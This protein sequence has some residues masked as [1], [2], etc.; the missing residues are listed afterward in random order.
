MLNEWAAYFAEQAARETGVGSMWQAY[1]RVQDAADWCE[2]AY[3][4]YE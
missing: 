1:Y 2:Y 4:Y 3:R